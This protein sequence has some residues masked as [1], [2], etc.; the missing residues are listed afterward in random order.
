M[1]AIVTTPFRVVNAENF[2]EDIAGSSVY[3]GI[4]KTDVWSTATSD[5]T[6]ASTPFT[7]QDRLDD[8]HETYQN[9]IGMKKILSSDVQHIV[10]RHT[11]AT[12]TSYIAWD[13]DDSAIYDKSFYVITS[14]YKVYKCTIA[15]ASGSIVEP[16]HINT[17]PTAE[18]DGYSWK[19]LYTLTVTDSEKFLTI[20]YMPVPTQQMPTTSVGSTSGSST[21]V[22]LTAANEY[23]KVGMLVTGSGITA[24]DTVTAVDGVTLTISTARTVASST[25]L[26]FGR[27][28]ETDINYA[29]QTAQ[30]N[31][32]ASST[33]AGIER[34]EVTAGGSS[35]DA[36]DVFTVA[37][38]GD[39]TGAT[40]VDANVTVASG[41]ITAI[42]V[43]AKGTD[44]TVADIVITHNNAS[45]GTAGSGATARA[46]IAPPDGHGVDPIKELGAF[47]VAINSQLTGS[48]AGDLTVGND[49]R[50][51]SLIKKPQNFGTT[52]TATASTL[53]ARKSLVLATG[54]SVANFAVDQVIVGSSSGAK[55]YLVEIDTTNKVLYYYQNSKTGYIPFVSGDTITGTLP[56]G[57]S[58]VLNTTSGTSWY[59]QATNT[60]GP[61]VRMNSGQLLFLENR[62]PINRSSSQ[63]EDI[64]LII[65]F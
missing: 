26:T 38:S 5:L 21:T 62:A 18:S 34:I 27:L 47:Y 13:S 32:L 46:V 57:G 6:D 42:A 16:T 51:I 35:Y 60:Y 31:S 61:E 22:T 9:L 4:G 10:P 58:S 56:S 2:K 25:T 48:E 37:I 44:Y 52:V 55:A 19:Y 29:N 24:G 54:G 17:N 8:L 43:N 28:G 59:G 39:G 63:I 65:E 3:V 50:Q 7:P 36:A 53:R 41:A 40:V 12:G 1:T 49:F 33:A 20:S 11:W 14:E 64:K 45:G 15:G 23:I 30:M